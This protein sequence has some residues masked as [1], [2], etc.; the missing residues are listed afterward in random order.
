ML[1]DKKHTSHDNFPSGHFLNSGIVH[2]SRTCPC[3]RLPLIV[4]IWVAI[5]LGVGAFLGPMTQLVAIETWLITSESCGAVLI[6]ILLWVGAFLGP[7]PHL[8]TVETGLITPQSSGA[9]L[10]TISFWQGN[11]ERLMEWFL[12]PVILSFRWWRPKLRCRWTELW[13][14]CD[15]RF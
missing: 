7:M 8:I 6:A 9:P 11:C 3:V 14:S 12:W 2:V 5:P 1:V 13:P 10:T 15:R 4:L